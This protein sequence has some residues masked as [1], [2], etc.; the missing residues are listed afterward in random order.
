LRS[1]QGMTDG[2]ATAAGLA[3][4]MAGGLLVRWSQ[5]MWRHAAPAPP[6]VIALNGAGAP[7]DV[8]GVV[9]LVGW[10][11]CA[12]TLVAAAHLAVMLTWA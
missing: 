12:G 7:P 10:V 9:W 1:P 8:S 4:I 2:E 11:W 3:V 5:D 6:A